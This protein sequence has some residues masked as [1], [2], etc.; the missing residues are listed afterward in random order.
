VKTRCRQ[1]T[2]F[3]ESMKRSQRSEVGETFYSRSALPQWWTLPSKA[4]SP[5]LAPNT[6]PTREQ[7]SESMGDVSDE[8]TTPLSSISLQVSF[9]KIS[10]VCP[11]P[12]LTNDCLRVAR[13]VVPSRCPSGLPPGN[14]CYLAQRFCTCQQG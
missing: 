6:P 12:A 7:I 10:I 11:L 8:A 14:S 3:T 9:H 5:K 13:W 1:L 4:V 2:P